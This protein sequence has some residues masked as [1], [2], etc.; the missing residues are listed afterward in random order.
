MREFQS[1]L[2]LWGATGIYIHLNPRLL[3]SIHAPLV[4]SDSG[5]NLEYQTRA[6]IS[7]HAPLVGSDLNPRGC[8][9]PSGISIHAP[10]V[11]SDLKVPIELILGVISIHAP[12]V[13]SDRLGC[14]GC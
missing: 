4:G 3:I 8:P 7:I 5:E 10:L 12:L 9:A 2:P 11:G 14:L 13:G 6:L 1:T